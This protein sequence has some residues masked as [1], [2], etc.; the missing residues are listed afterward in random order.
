MPDL[1]SVDIIA[2]SLWFD[3]LLDVTSM[4]VSFATEMPQPVPGDGL[5]LML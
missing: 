3:G 1:D 4:V 5:V 2:N